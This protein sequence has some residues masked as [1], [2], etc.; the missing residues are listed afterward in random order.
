[1]LVQ[2][3]VALGEKGIKKLVARQIAE[4]VECLDALFAKRNKDL[5]SER[6]NLSEFVRHAQFL[7]LLVQFLVALGEVHAGAVAQLL[8][9]VL[10][11]PFD[12]GQLL[13]RHEGNLLDRRK[14]LGH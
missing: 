8:G 1:M 11:E 10:A 9:D 12:R 6:G 2:F 7:A 3:L 13:E 4:V 5:W 14:P